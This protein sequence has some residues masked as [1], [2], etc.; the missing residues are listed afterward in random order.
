M[1]NRTF[2][3]VL[4]LGVPFFA[5]LARV[6]GILTMSKSGTPAL[7]RSGR[8]YIPGDEDDEEEDGE[9]LPSRLCFATG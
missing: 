3:V 7:V 6:V 8:L 5:D 4:L 9:F 2:A 1:L